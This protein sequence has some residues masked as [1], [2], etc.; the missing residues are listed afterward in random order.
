MLNAPCSVDL[1]HRQSLSM[2]KGIIGYRQY[3]LWRV[4][5]FYVAR[6]IS[7]F[8]C[9]KLG[10]VSVALV[11]YISACRASIYSVFQYSVLPQV[12]PVCQMLPVDLIYCGADFYTVS[13]ISTVLCYNHQVPSTL[14]CVSV[15]VV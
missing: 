1:L 8:Q 4:G 5:N 15:C 9:T 12:L 14:Q 10:K 3:R 11:F 7:A 2:S 13:L 6:V